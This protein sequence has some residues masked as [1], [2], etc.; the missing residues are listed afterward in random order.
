MNSSRKLQVA[1]N[2]ALRAV[3]RRDNRSDTQLLHDDSEIEW[4]DIQRKVNC[5]VQTYKLT[6]G[7]GLPNL[8]DL[9]RPHTNV[10]PLRSSKGIQH[11]RSISKSLFAERDFVS[12]SMHLSS[13]A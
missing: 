13:R 8:T 5:C 2:Q 11:D 3:L 6:N 1:Q 7:I 12:R 4:L 9:F 10:C